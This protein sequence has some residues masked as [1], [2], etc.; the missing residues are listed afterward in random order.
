VKTLKTGLFF[1]KQKIKEFRTDQFFE[2]QKIK[3][4]EPISRFNIFKE[5]K[6]ADA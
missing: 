1:E 5:P 6:P 4:S 2:K 3:E